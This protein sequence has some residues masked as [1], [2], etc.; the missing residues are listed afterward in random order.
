M[1]GSRVQHGIPIVGL[2]TNVLG[3][4]GNSFIAL[5]NDRH[6]VR[7]ILEHLDGFAPSLSFVV[8]CPSAVEFLFRLPFLAAVLPPQRGLALSKVDRI[9]VTVRSS[10][11]ENI[12][13]FLLCRAILTAASKPARAWLSGLSALA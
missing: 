10:A 13:K 8:Y 12:R 9:S 2:E 11:P 3:S 7:Q 4:F 5:V 1:T 6:V